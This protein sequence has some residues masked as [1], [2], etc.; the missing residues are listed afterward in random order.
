MSWR[1]APSERFTPPP[2]LQRGLP[3]PVPFRSLD[4]GCCIGVSSCTINKLLSDW[5][6]SIVYGASCCLA[7]FQSLRAL[8][9]TN[10]IGN[11]LEKLPIEDASQRVLL[12][13][14]REAATVRV[15]LSTAV[16]LLAV[17][18]D[19]LILFS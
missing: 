17:I 13:I 2:N 7:F 19:K 10:R 11:E 15:Y 14:L 8:R 5:E 3:L 12:M 4:R 18:A 1:S 16:V 6:R 9:A